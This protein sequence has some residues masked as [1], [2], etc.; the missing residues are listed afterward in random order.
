MYFRRIFRKTYRRG[1]GMILVNEVGHI[2]LGKRAK[3][4]EDT[5][6]MPQGGIDRGETLTQAMKRE[7]MEE[8]GTNA[9]EIIAESA[10]WYRYDF[11]TILRDNLWG[12]RFRGQQQ[13][14]FLLRFTGTDAMINIATHHQEFSAWQWASKEETLSLVV[15]F[16]EELYQ[17]VLSDMWPMLEK[18]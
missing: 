10:Q 17:Q 16:K 11:P 13:K 3:M 14:W 12:G 18:A 15:G 7:M 2:F 8:V 5:W 1:V 4:Q 6:Q 9:F